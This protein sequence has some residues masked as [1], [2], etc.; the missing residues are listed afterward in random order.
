M[1]VRR[2]VEEEAKRPQPARE[3][4]SI[5]SYVSCVLINISSNTSS[6]QPV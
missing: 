6:I 3:G 2:E 4:S 5:P 1:H